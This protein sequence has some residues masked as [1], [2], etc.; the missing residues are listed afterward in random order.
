MFAS[1]PAGSAKRAPLDFDRDDSIELSGKRERIE[2]CAAA[3]V[4]SRLMAHVRAAGQK[5]GDTLVALIL[6]PMD[7]VW[8]GRELMLSEIGVGVSHG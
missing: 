3:H 6:N 8:I 7:R 4:E 2:P 1:D 5:L